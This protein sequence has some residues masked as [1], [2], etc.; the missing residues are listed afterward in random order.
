MRAGGAVKAGLVAA[1]LVFTQLGACSSRHYERIKVDSPTPP[2]ICR[3]G[4]GADFFILKE[5]ERCAVPVPAAYALTRTRIAVR[6]GESYRIEHLPGQI[7]YD[8]E[9]RLIALEGERGSLLMRMANGLKKKEQ[10][11][12]FALIA[13]VVAP[14]GTESTT[15]WISLG[16]R[17]DG[18]TS[19]KDVLKITEDGELGL[20]P[21]DA[22]GFYSNNQ[23]LLW[24]R[25]SRCTTTCTP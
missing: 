11:P 20:Y 6:A 1:L 22:R 18:D 17:R 7:W 8:A 24:V 10:Q 15:N 19:P 25:V 12:Y 16:D 9:R 21:N 5:N 4:A 14:D 2:G 13:V 23:G 3:M